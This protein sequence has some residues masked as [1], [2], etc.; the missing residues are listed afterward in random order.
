MNVRI[1]L[2]LGWVVAAALTH[3]AQPDF[4]TA[5]RPLLKEFCLDCHSTDQQKGELD[6][7]QFQSLTTVKQQPEIWQKVVEQLANGEMP[8]D[9][10]PQPTSSQRDQLSQWARSILDDIALAHAGDPGPVL[11]R[12]LSNAEYTY[13]LQDLTGVDLDPAREF[14]ADGAAGEGFMN[15]GNALV[16]S[17]ALLAKYLDAGKDV[18][19]HAVL[20][21]DGF[22]FSTN[23]S[24]R[25][26]T[27]D[28]LG[29][30]RSFY[31][32]FTDQGGG[33]SVNLQGVQFDTNQGGLLPLAAYLMATLAEREA[34]RLHHESIEAVARRRGLSPKYL[35]LLWGELNRDAEVD[36]SPLMEWLRARWRV[37]TTND[38]PA[39][40][41]LVADWQKDLWTFNAVGQ[42]G[43]K[44]SAP[45]W[46][47]PVTPL[48]D[49]RELRLTLPE[50]ESGRDVVFFLSAGDAGDGN[51]S[52]VVL[53]ENARLEGEGLPTIPLRK[54]RGMQESLAAY[55]QGT[56]EKTEFYLAAIAEA[57]DPIDPET[58]AAR[59]RLES[60]ILQAWLEYLDLGDAGPAKVEGNYDT[61]LRKGAN[62]EFINGWGSDDT[63]SIVANS[64]DQEV[65]IPGRARPHSIVAHPSPTLF[66]AAGWQSPLDGIVRVDAV[67]TDAHPE[68]GNGVEWVVQHRTGR[69]V[70]S[71]WQ[72]QFGTGG[73]ATMPAQR[74]AVR[75]GE[76]VSLLL[77][78]RDGNHSCD[79]TDIN[80]V[81]TETTGDQRVWNLAQ[82]VSGDILAGNPHSDRFGNAGVWHFYRGAMAAWD[83][84]QKPLNAVPTMSLMAQWI[85]ARD[86]ATRSRLASRIQALA[87][88]SAPATMETPDAV[89][90][91]QLQA[92]A[93]PSDVSALL[94]SATDDERF[95]QHPLGGNADPAQ[96][97]VKAPSVLEFHVPP[98]LARGRELVVMARLDNSQN[99]EGTAQVRLDTM[100]PD[101]Q[102]PWPHIPFLAG[103]PMAK[104]RLH[105][106]LASF[107]QLFPPAL[108]YT[109][110]V[111]VDEVVT[112]TLFYREDEHL[113][114]LM[115]D[116]E[117]IRRLDQLWE[118]L[119]YVSQE[120][121]KL[122]VALEQLHQFATQDRADLVP[123]F[124]A[125]KEP[126][127]RRADAFAL[128]MKAAEPTHL[129]ALLEFAGRAYRR[130]LTSADAEALRGLYQTLRD[131]ELSHEQSFQF[132]MA[133]VLTTPAF[134]YRLESPGEGSGSSP[135]TD[136]ELATRLSYFLW[137]SLPDADLRVIAET[138]MLRNPDQL[139]AQ[140]RRM[141]ADTRV[142]RLATEFAC[143]WLHIRDFDQ[144]DEKSERHFP[145]FAG[146]RADMR[147]ESIHFFTDLF[148]NNGP[149]LSIL[150]ADHTFLN[151]PLA[152]FY[153][154]P[155][156]TGPEWRRVESMRR[157]S[158]GGILTF[159]ATL[160]RQSG[161]S[162]TSP[163]L[164]GN[165][166]SETLLG[167]RLPRPPKDV[168]QL[169]D[170]VP[171]GLTER[172]LIER[173][174]SDPACAKCHRR[175]D[176]YGFALEAFDA[177]GRFRGKD[178]AG[179]PIDTRT[180]LLDGTLIEGVEG[181]RAYVSSTRRDA[182][183][184]QFCRKLLGYALGRAVQLSDEPLL[185]EMADH[186]RD[187]DGRFH[188]L[189][190]RIVLSRQFREIRGTQSGE[191]KSL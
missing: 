31:A 72:G 14:P 163:I 109:K 26:W 117:Q 92:L 25:D 55:R 138:G 181:L 130:P 115:L 112:L 4:Q 133:R 76:L 125:L 164:R 91:H 41:D 44:G 161:A 114:R 144:L 69:R 116:A 42:I 73:T 65:R 102:E 83:R 156:V 21:P 68:C 22:R 166:V 52:D 171:E 49:R 184:H 140:T 34:L 16:M 119:E 27:D 111:P 176:P 93:T 17:P 53:W 160:A 118:E 113:Q 177:I 37:A 15:T 128:N 57:E 46:M 108:C 153:G 107:R 5:I 59:H 142:R 30:I 33:A 185:T 106:G 110:I 152:R 100:P 141:L 188:S 66:T 121:F 101:N 84:E 70:G 169:P 87:L 54:A 157:F 60:N 32:P 137:S 51:D 168:P 173:H 165:W 12:R 62:Y 139:L 170:E 38:L 149:V 79:L 124:V 13:T 3:S 19:R 90:Y 104:G 45:S 48:S 158:R 20:L 143:Q 135:V 78:P 162:R 6:L 18:A 122:V 174:A 131:Q 154:V 63:P 40:V 180:Q 136:L 39:L 151:E 82:D 47:Q 81:I 1:T 182:F 190:E 126:V 56:L 183:L 105:A 186:V 132:T 86:A 146:L 36:S 2:C 74:I 155:D 189:V 9:K 50:P 10:K 29:R 77:G 172:Q 71:L 28:L 88:G 129:E 89:L 61:M 97:L 99:G 23:T 179:H 11:L 159:A 150:D 95:G 67:L 178:S 24:S 75:R 98:D 58:L 8:P 167:E 147:Q 191:P 120:P 43:R 123:E 96:L 148:Q 145:E 85:E 187:G 94:E 134:L 64:S 80:L 35:G 7:E 103:G 175:I 127:Q